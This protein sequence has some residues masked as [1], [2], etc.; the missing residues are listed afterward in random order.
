[1]ARARPERAPRARDSG[2]GGG[3][4]PRPRPSPKARSRHRPEDAVAR[5]APRARAEESVLS[6]VGVVCP[7]CGGTLA[8]AECRGCASD[9]SGPLGIVDLARQ[10]DGDPLTEELLRR[11]ETMSFEELFA[12]YQPNLKAGRSAKSAR[13]NVQYATEAERR[14]E[15]MA[16]MFSRAVEKTCGRPL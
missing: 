6:F 4:A 12:W 1:G 7:R 2:P 16:V 14:T 9:W 10:D 15:R 13:A 5:D 3:R 8:G 11:A